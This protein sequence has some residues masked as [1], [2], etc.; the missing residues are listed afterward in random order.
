M[1]FSFFSLSIPI[2]SVNPNFLCQIPIFSVSPFF[3]C[4]F[5]IFLC[6]KLTAKL[7]LTKNSDIEFTNKSFSLVK[8]RFKQSFL[9]SL[10]F[11]KTQLLFYAESEGKQTRSDIEWT[12][13]VVIC[14]SRT[15]EPKLMIRRL[16]FFIV[17]FYLRVER[18]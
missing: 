13:I 3:L 17:P 11:M 16:P 1:W 12:T 4:Q 15:Q 5:P 10:N 14:K 18:T 6:Q 9:F 7:V 2:F 8:T